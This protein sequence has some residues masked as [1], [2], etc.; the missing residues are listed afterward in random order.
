MKR[1][2]SLICTVLC[3]QKKQLVSSSTS[4][5]D[6][7][8]GHPNPIL[9]VPH[10][11]CFNLDLSIHSIIL[12]WRIPGTV[13]RGGLPSMGS[14]SWT[15]L[16]RLSSSSSRPLSRPVSQDPWCGAQKLPLT[17]GSSFVSGFR[18]AHPCLPTHC[19]S[20]RLQVGYDASIRKWLPTRL[21][22]CTKGCTRRGNDLPQ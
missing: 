16:K 15:R 18:L 5:Y 8:P 2:A 19:R 11:L 21:P 12:A 6:I 10:S 1:R 9:S 14:H 4:L 3:R 22:S 13:E 20:S 7:F 17:Q